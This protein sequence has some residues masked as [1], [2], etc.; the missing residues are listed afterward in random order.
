MISLFPDFHKLKLE[1]Q[2]CVK[3]I[4]RRYPPYCEYSILA[5]LTWYKIE[6]A[7][8]DDNLVL[9]MRDFY[10]DHSAAYSVLGTNNIDLTIGKVLTR[11]DK[12]GEDPELI[13]VPEPVIYALKNPTRFIYKEDIDNFDYVV[14]TEEMATLK[15]GR[16]QTKRE[17]FKLFSKKYPSVKLEAI[18]L[19]N[20]II[21]KK[22]KYLYNIW[23]KNSGRP[24][25]TLDH[26]YKAVRELFTISD[27]LDILTHGLFHNKKLIAFSVVGLVNKPYAINYYI[28]TDLRYRGISVS[29]NKLIGIELL[30]LGFKYLNLEAD[31]GIPGLKKSKQLRHPVEFLKK[32][33][34]RL[35]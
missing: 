4:T 22:I 20:E 1:D 17:L 7:L 19:K 11:I 2:F 32:Y 21:Q 27:K 24:N 5:L 6:I 12:D 8:L 23:Y 14:S 34:I 25:N 26:E 35:S 30:N 28:K 33:S 13:L 9:K 18:D 15:G 29:F 3:N 31:L 10:N 16:N